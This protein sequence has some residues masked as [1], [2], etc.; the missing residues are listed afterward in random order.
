MVGEECRRRAIQEPR[1]EQYMAADQRSE[2][3]VQLY[4][5]STLGESQMQ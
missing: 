4:M 1:Q 2:S 3:A 5:L